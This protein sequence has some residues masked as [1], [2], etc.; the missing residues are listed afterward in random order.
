[1][2]GGTPALDAAAHGLAGSLL[3]GGEGQ[4]LGEGGQEVLERVQE[5]KALEDL[6]HGGKRVEGYHDLQILGAFH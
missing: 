5:G 3:H 1:M 4:E 6:H 2:V